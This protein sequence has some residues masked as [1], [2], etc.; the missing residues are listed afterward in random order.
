MLL[1]DEPEVSLHPQLQSYLLREMKTAANKYGKTIIVS[2]HSAEMIELG[3]A[4]DLSNF[5][6]FTNNE[7]P[8]QIAPDAE[9]LKNKQ[10]QD[11]ILRMSLAYN[12]GFFAKKVLLIEGSSDM[13]MCR[14]LCN[15]FD[16][17]LDIAGSQIIPIEGKGQFAV[18]TKLFRLIGKEVC[19]LTDLDGFTDDNSIIN[20]FSNLPEATEIANKY[21][22]G[23]LQTMI[24]DVKT[25][26]E[27]LISANKANMTSIYENHPYWIHR[28]N[29]TEE[30]KILRRSIIAQLLT[31]REEELLTWPASTE[32]KSLKIRINVLMGILEE[33]GCFVLRKGA[34]ESYYVFSPKTTYSGKPSAAALEVSSLQETDNEKIAD[35]YAD[36][37]R[38]LKYASLDKK[39]D[40]SFAVKKELLSELALVL[41]ILN[42]V[43]SENNISAAIKQAKSNA[44]SLFNYKL[45]QEND[46]KGVEISLKSQIIDVEGFPFKAFDGDNVN[47]V[48]KTNIRQK[49]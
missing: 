42:E 43:S 22:S 25:K 21:G 41:G 1:V 31:V 9:E 8:K 19:V 38:A 11:F 26:V 12:E 28:D 13:I 44:Q 27:S 35:Y 16:L 45:I 18:I 30:D 10:L 6:F 5:V 3:N 46:R 47:Q 2:T 14:Y 32:W 20:L 24:S 48:V 23:A 7:L 36:L 17:N 33:L 40:E 49:Q 37:I 34:I 29:D 15:R 39:V 4:K